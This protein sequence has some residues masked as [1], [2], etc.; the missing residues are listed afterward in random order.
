MVELTANFLNEN[1]I[2]DNLHLIQTACDLDISNNVSE[3]I[4]LQNEINKPELKSVQVP[5]S[6]ASMID[7]P[8]NKQDLSIY[9]Q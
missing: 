4:H 2:K 6:M 9:I 7:D 1:G 3:T 8:L 5:L